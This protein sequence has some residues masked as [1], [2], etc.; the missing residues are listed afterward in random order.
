MSSAVTRIIVSGAAGRM[1]ARVCALA[2]GDASFALVGALE[3]PASPA[4]GR[5]ACAPAQGANGPEISG[6][7]A[8]LAPGSADVVIDFSSGA[9]ALRAAAL[10]PRIGAA[11]LVGTTGLGAGDLEEIR[12]A[13]AR[14]AVLVAPN[15]SLGVAA[16]SALVAR[17]A[18]L[19]GPEYAC[20][21]VEAHHSAKID[22]PSG[23]A[24]RLAEAARGA[25]PPHGADQVVS[26]RGGDVIGEHTVRFAGPGEYLEITHRATSRDLFARGALRA[27]QWLRGRAAGVYTMEDVLGIHA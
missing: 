12:R 9:G 10:A 11:L 7:D 1:G 14:V 19:L 23:T 27:A 15:T 8:D 26:I 13:G 6:S 3:S 4:L 17:A 16:V 22:A 2:H 20:S 25:R 24:L 21:I 5:A 18:A